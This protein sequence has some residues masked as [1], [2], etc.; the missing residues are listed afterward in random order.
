M[1]D[2]SRRISIVIATRNRKSSLLLTLGRLR[3]AYPRV[4]TIVVDNGSTDG[5]AAAVREQFAWAEIIELGANRGAVAR[6]YGAERADTSYVAFND[7]DSWWAPGALPLAVNIFDA[8]PSLGLIT[9]QVLVG[10]Q[11]R[12]DPTCAEMARSPLRRGACSQ[13]PAVLGFLAAGAIV[14]RSAFR[15]AGGFHSRYGIGGEEEL[16]AIDMAASGWELAYIDWIVAYHHPSGQARNNARRTTV[17]LRNALWTAW[18]RRRVGGA[19]GR[20][21]RL[22]ARAGTSRATLEALIAA[23]GGLPWVVRER[24]RVPPELESDLRSLESN[25]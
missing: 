25:A 7:D 22:I 20:T 12:L 3:H 21:A 8:H 10:P 5:T 11:A 16:L 15:A 14:R 18:L 2:V 6:N 23:L 13:W 19:L 24:R 1:D 17:Q 9:G 4:R